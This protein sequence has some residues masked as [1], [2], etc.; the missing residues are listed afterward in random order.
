MAAGEATKFTPIELTLAVLMVIIA[1]TSIVVAF[2]PGM[3]AYVG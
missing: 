2:I 3:L 1:A